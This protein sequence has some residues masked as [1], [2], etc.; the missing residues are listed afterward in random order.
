MILRKHPIDCEPS[1]APSGT[2][3][4]PIEIDADAEEDAEEDENEG[5]E[6]PHFFT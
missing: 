4:D 5:P 2:A 6:Q 1:T 3:R